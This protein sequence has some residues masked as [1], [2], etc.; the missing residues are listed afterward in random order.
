MVGVTTTTT[1]AALVAAIPEVSLE[2]RFRVTT[3]TRGPG[4]R[5]ARPMVEV[6]GEELPLAIARVS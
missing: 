3:A 5:K 1:L 4:V 6:L 2:L